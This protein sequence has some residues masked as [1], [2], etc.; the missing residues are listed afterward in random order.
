[1]QSFIIDN[2]TFKDLNVLTDDQHSIFSLFKHTR[3]LGGRERL[4]QMMQNPSNDINA[5][6]F[7]RDSIAYFSSCKIE[8]DIRNEE[9]DLIEFYLKFDKRKSKSNIIDSI[10][11]YLTKNSSNRTQI[12]D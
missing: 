6:I 2:Q 5:L 1:M 10:A 11:D 3:T 4:K 9:L 7:R 12:P 8:F